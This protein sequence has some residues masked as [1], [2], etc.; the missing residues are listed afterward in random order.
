M[1]NSFGASAVDLP[2]DA[3]IKPRIASKEQKMLFTLGSCCHHVLGATLK[4][5]QQSANCTFNTAR[6][7]TQIMWDY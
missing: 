1:I 2:Q 4:C 5:W 7:F 3:A 6:A